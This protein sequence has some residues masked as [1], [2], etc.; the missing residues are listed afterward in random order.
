[1]K[2]LGAILRYGVHVPQLRLPRAAIASAIGWTSAPERRPLAGARAICNWDE[3]ALTLGVEAARTCLR[4][5]KSPSRLDS[6]SLASTSSPFADRDTAAALV[7]ALDLPDTL[8]T[9]N[10]GGSL[11]AGTSALLNAAHQS[12]THT[13]LVIAS[14]ARLTQ[15]GSSQEMLYGDAAAAFMIGAA[16]P[17]ALASIVAAVSINSDFVDHY[18]MSGSDFDY[19]LEERWIRDESLATLV[20]RALGELFEQAG[21]SLAD[22]RHLVLPTSEATAER[23]AKAAG[24]SAAQRDATL[25]TDCGDAGCAA[26][27]L[28]L[29]AALERA[30]P[31]ELIVLIGLGQGIDA[32]LLR[33]EDGVSN[34]P[35]ALS[36]ALAA[37][38]EESSYIRYLSHRGLIDIDFGMRAERDQR[39]A[40]S[41]AFR[42]RSAIMAFVGGKCSSCNTVQF[43]RARVCVNPSC[44]LQ[45]TQTPFRL[46]DS[47][48]RVKTFTEDWQAFAMR[49]PYLY[50]NVEFREGGN[51]FM[52]FTDADAGDLKVNDTVRFV[53]R[54]KDE[55]RVR[56]FR[57]YFWKAAK[58]LS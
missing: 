44:R 5:S 24:L 48:G 18:R 19:G 8:N 23:L 17:G 38:R 9:S 21:C 27:L 28:Q 50:G 54:I 11:R 51:L 33:A 31:G 32:L 49:P 6:V 58:V 15:P 34:A 56:K 1:M 25:A 46:A 42:K 3:D 26:P 29:A 57:R 12:T 41:V 36:N 7:A 37:R 16:R 30:A 14:D 55:D 39:T 13:T 43:P 4:L 45:D 2:T 10:V 47:T 40:H 22:I 20:P 52:E 53:F 35:H